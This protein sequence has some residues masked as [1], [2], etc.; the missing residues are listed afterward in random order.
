MS[1]LF[2]RSARVVPGP[3]KPVA[4]A[5]NGTLPI[6]VLALT[7]ALIAAGLAL[8]PHVS[9]QRPAGSPAAAEIA[10]SVSTPAPAKLR[11]VADIPLDVIAPSDMDEPALAALPAEPPTASAPTAQAAPVGDQ[12]LFHLD[13]LPVLQADGPELDLGTSTANPAAKPASRR[14]PVTREGPVGVTR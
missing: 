3:L 11:D 7:A 12:A 14:N 6:T 5:G 9:Q 8:I 10:Q 4:V 1:R 2:G 13:T